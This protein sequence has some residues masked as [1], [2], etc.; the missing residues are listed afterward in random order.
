VLPTDFHVQP[1]E[2]PRP[3]ICPWCLE[4]AARCLRQ[5]PVADA[6]RLGVAE[7]LRRLDAAVQRG[8]EARVP[9]CPKHR[10]LLNLT[11]RRPAGQRLR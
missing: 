11:R 9:R 6:D 3:P 2:P 10:R 4:A 7:F 8:R 1:C 5:L